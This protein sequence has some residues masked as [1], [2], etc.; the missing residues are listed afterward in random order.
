[1]SEET[2][3][4]QQQQSQA[5]E[6]STEETVTPVLKTNDETTSTLKDAE[7]ATEAREQETEEALDLSQ[8]KSQ[9]SHESKEEPSPP[10]QEDREV[11]P[12]SDVEMKDAP[13]LSTETPE[14]PT[15]A[16]EEVAAF[17]ESTKEEAKSSQPE[18][19]TAAA[20][21]SDA[22]LPSSSALAKKDQESSRDQKEEV[23][24]QTPASV[25]PANP[26]LQA[27]NTKR[28]A[29]VEKLADLTAQRASLIEASKLPSGLDMPSTWSDEEKEKHG[30]KTANATIKEHISLLHKY[31]EIKDIGLGLMGLVAEKRGVRQGVVMEEY[32][33]SKD[34]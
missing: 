6:I 5:P 17:Q 16:K 34:D 1:M 25:A 14:Q 2:L 18:T 20:S 28:A 26:R 9:R 11:A 13:A 22:P 15:Q 21:S 23:Q 30:M 4:E 19:K 29:L 33:I 27:L 24:L 10:Q 31:N 7:L 32:G 8:A 12:A 3:P